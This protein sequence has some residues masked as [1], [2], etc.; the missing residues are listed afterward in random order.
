MCI[1]LL[2]YKMSKDVI[3][4]LKWKYFNSRVSN[5]IKEQSQYDVTLVSDDHKPFLAHKYVLGAVSQVLKTILLNNP[6]PH[7]LIYLKGVN[8]Q[9][10]NSILQFIYFGKVCVDHINMRK[11]ADAAEDLQIK[12]LSE[13]IR[14]GKPNEP[15]DNN[16]DNKDI[17]QLKEEKSKNEY[18]R[19]SLLDISGSDELGSGKELFKCEECKAS[20]K[21]KMGLYYHTS[22]KHE[23][24]SYSCKYCDYHATTQGHL[25]R[26][27]GSIH[28]GVRY[29]CD[30]CDYQATQQS[31]LFTHKKSVHEGI[32]YS[33]NQCHFHATKK[34]KIEIHKKSVHRDVE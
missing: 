25:K 29:S 22:S 14:I 8:H 21:S 6:H 20:Y 27:Q 2:Y 11:F 26:H 19:S 10:L 24:I 5:T 4:T 34:R 33:C 28:E 23:G 13:I 7:P 31:N 12:K 16:N 17:H 32:R 18:A 3:C 1:S 15:K 9:E 30:Q